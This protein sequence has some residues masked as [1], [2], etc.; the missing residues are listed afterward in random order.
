MRPV[1][2]A[3]TDETAK[4]ANQGRQDPGE[5]MVKMVKMAKRGQLV[6]EEPMALP[7]RPEQ[8]AE[9]VTRAP[10]ARR[11]RRV[12]P[13]Q[14]VPLVIWDHKGRLAKPVRQDRRA[15]LAQPAKRASQGRKVLPS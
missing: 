6:R 9:P 3:Q 2:R 7:V 11:E 10:L 5:Q 13:G 1:L 12:I 14:P 15:P 4:T 8:T